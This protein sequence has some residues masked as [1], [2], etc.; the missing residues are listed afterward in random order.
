MTGGGKW[1]IDGTDLSLVIGFCN[2]EKGGYKN[3]V[4]IR[5]WNEDPRWGYDNSEDAEAK[6]FTQ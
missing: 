2:P 6:Q 4:G 1:N 5:A 3:I